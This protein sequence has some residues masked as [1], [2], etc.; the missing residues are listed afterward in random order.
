M[1]KRSHYI[2]LGLVVLLVL[3]LLNLPSQTAA[4]FKLAIGGLFLPLFGLASSTHNMVE[5]AG[6]TIV[7]RSVLLS[8]LKRLQTEND[9]LRIESVQ[10]EQVLR[11]N[12][13]LREAIS[14]QR[15]AKWKLKLARVISRDPANWWR[16][17][18]IDV[19]V[20]DGV[21][22]NSPVLTPEG[23]VGRVD[24]AGPRSARV[25]LL[26]DPNCRVSAMIE[27]SREAGILGSGSGSLIDQNMLDLTYLPAA[28]SVEPGQRVV[29]SGLGGV[30]PPGIPIGEIADS[31]T[32]GYGLYR[33]ARVKLSANLKQL[34]EVWVKLP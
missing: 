11:E 9:R 26:G 7:P 24:Q 8:E 17:M 10:Q 28:V 3:I 4:Q 25:L 21:L 2:V 1:F 23:L 13:E 34:E 30:F 22:T 12:N 20:R 29:T 14:W 6:D 18:Q 5:K 27:K 33:E 16:S 15:H 31:R 32:V 19:G